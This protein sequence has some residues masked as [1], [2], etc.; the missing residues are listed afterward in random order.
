V[1]DSSF[2]LF[3]AQHYERCVRVAWRVV[4]RGDIARDLA[5]EAFARAWVRWN[6]LRDQ[7]P[8]AWVAKVTLNLAID[9]VRRRALEPAAPAPAPSPEDA[10]ITR[11]TLATALGALP[12][13]QRSAI[14]LRYLEDRSEDEIATALHVSKGTVKVHLHRGLKR[15][16]ALLDDPSGDATKS[17]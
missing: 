3:F 1:T 13:Q 11:V 10:S 15:L 14:A 4:G 7:V 17:A 6:Q 9:A 2:D 5:A 8:G 12:A 16:R